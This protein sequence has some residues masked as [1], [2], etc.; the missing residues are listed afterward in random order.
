MTGGAGVDVAIEISGHYA[1]LGY[2]D[3][4]GALRRQSSARRVRLQAMRPN[5]GWAANF[6]TNSLRMIVPRGNGAMEFAPS[7][8]PLWDQ[9]RV[10]DSNRE[11]DEAGQINRARF[12]RPARFDRGI[13]G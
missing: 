6:L 13:P 10:F 3:S 12:N 9:Y 5:C 1:A 11:H 8:Y 2:G 4:G 7:D